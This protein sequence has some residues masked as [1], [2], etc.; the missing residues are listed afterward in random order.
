MIDIL[1]DALGVLGL[2]GDSGAAG[3]RCALF[4]L[5]G[6]LNVLRGLLLDLLGVLRAALERV[7]F[8]G[9]LLDDCVHLAR[10]RRHIG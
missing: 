4:R 7:P 8:G 9:L 5:P 6:V 10:S 3:D 2:D 1:L